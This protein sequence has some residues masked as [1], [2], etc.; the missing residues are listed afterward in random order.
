MVPSSPSARRIYERPASTTPRRAHQI[1]PSTRDDANGCRHST[2]DADN[3]TIEC[4]A[5]H[6]WGFESPTTPSAGQ[7]TMFTAHTVDTNPPPSPTT[8][9]AIWPDGHPD[10]RTVVGSSVRR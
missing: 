2:A 3:Y 5:A 1:S 10:Q 6:A 9:F 8:S 4:R 7:F